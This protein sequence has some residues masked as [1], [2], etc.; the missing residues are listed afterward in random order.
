[1]PLKKKKFN[2]QKKKEGTKE[3][4]KFRNRIE[5]ITLSEKC[6]NQ[7]QHIS[8]RAQLQKHESNRKT[9]VHAGK[10]TGGLT[11]RRR[12]LVLV[13]QLENHLQV[14]GKRESGSS[15]F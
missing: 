15:G 12:A 6:Q 14:V 11:V 7:E 3:I 5:V 13:T 10:V 4:L 8:T 9:V 1:M 2:S